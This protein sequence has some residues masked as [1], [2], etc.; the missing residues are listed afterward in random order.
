MLNKTGLVAV[1][2]LLMLSL[3]LW[4][5]DGNPAYTDAKEAG[6]DFRIQ[7]EYEGTIDA[8]GSHW[9]AQVIALGDGT[10]RSIGYPGGLPGNGWQA[11][12]ETTNTEGKLAG[13]SATF[14]AGEFVVRVNG[15]NLVVESVEGDEIGKLPAVQRKSPTLGAQPPAGAIVLFDGSNVDH[16]QDGKMTDDHYLASSNTETKQSF[17]D[18]RLHLEFRTPFMPKSRGQARGNSG[19]YVQSRYEIQ[20]LDSFGLEGRD[21]EC[22]GIYSISAQKLTCAF[23]RSVGRPTTSILR[24]RSLMPTETKQPMHASRFATMVL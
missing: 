19:V 14:D 24:R 10:F 4:A 16:W 21:N 9:G 3:Q 6:I 8:D 20:V 23:R 2:S 12:S 1:V 18:H 11:G 22:G 5:A 17:G 15:A 13:D 7:G